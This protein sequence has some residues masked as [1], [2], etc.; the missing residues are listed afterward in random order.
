MKGV[1]DD[2][3]GPDIDSMLRSRI[4]IDPDADFDP[5][6]LFSASLDQEDI[7]GLQELGLNVEDEDQDLLSLKQIG[8]SPNN[9]S[10][11]EQDTGTANASMRSYSEQDKRDNDRF[12]DGDYRNDDRANNSDHN[13]DRNKNNSGKRKSNIQNLFV[14]SSSSPESSIVHERDQQEYNQG[15]EHFDPD[16]HD[17]GSRNHNR[18]S[19]HGYDAPSPYNSKADGESDH[20]NPSSERQPSL[21]HARNGRREKRDPHRIAEVQQ[22]ILHVQRKIRE[23]QHENMDQEQMQQNHQMMGDPHRHQQHYEQQEHGY[24]Q[25]GNPHPPRYQH[26]QHPQHPQHSQHRPSQN[27]QHQHHLERHER[28]RHDIHERHGRREHHER[29]ERHQRDQHHHHQHRGQHLP[30]HSHRHPHPQHQLHNH[31]HP[32]YRYAESYGEDSYHNNTK[33]RDMQRDSGFRPEHSYNGP[34]SS[35]RGGDDGFRGGLR[36]H[37]GPGSHQPPH[38][39]PHQHHGDSMRPQPLNGGHCHDGMRSDG[40]GN[41]FGPHDRM[42]PM[43][44]MRRGHPSHP[45]AHSPNNVPPFSNNSRV[46]FGGRSGG[47]QQQQH[48]VGGMSR[49]L[50]GIPGHSNNK[51]GNGP[52]MQQHGRSQDMPS[53]MSRSLNGSPLGRRMQS[54]NMNNSNGVMRA[55]MGIQSMSDSLNGM[56]NG[57]QPIDRHNKNNSLP[58]MMERSNN[59]IMQQQNMM[60]ASNNRSMQPQ[61]GIQS[62]SNSLNGIQNSNNGSDGNRNNLMTNNSISPQHSRG[63]QSMARSLNGAQQGSSGRRMSRSLNGM[64]DAEG[65]SDFRRHHQGHHP[66]AQGMEM[67][68]SL[69]GMQNMQQN[70]ND[71][72]YR[73]HQQDGMNRSNPMSASQNG[74]PNMNGSQDDY[75]QQQPRGGQNA[76]RGMSQSL[77]GAQNNSYTHFNH[78]QPA[79]DQMNNITGNR[80]KHTVI[81]GSNEM[82]QSNNMSMNASNNGPV[83]N[84]SNVP[85]APLLN[86]VSNLA[87]LPNRGGGNSPRTMQQPQ[88]QAPMA[89]DNPESPSEQGG[90][91]TSKMGNPMALAQAT[92]R[93]ASSR[94]MI[95]E[96][97]LSLVKLQRDAGSGGQSKSSSSSSTKPTVVK[98]KRNSGR[99]SYS[100]LKMEATVR[101]HARQIKVQ[102]QQT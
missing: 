69:N 68:R 83:L 2:G 21:R 23:A 82:P 76:L 84:N 58:S 59:G 6:C 64:P 94:K 44:S 37:D 90:N 77:N 26:P 67:S 70:Y 4:T 13:H 72:T 38:L 1:G 65:N 34:R 80:D 88:G 39:P 27:Q 85:S 91:G 11:V 45:M 15:Q 97:G 33:T 71:G 47:M 49:S 74:M 9:S 53:R 61:R 18:R 41:D 31:T 14:A 16:P 99:E 86:Q 75:G 5:S 96:L 89:E 10:Q 62:M 81:H 22:R 101:E 36:R 30:P 3:N 8:A 40:N 102:K 29:H 42:H 7:D 20:G 50:N 25:D 56:S 93:S 73:H 51:M 52:T 46:E 100:S 98:A 57:T 78:H 60:D 12:Y 95:K 24:A 92:M 43:D 28:E 48:V 32:Q 35:M 54:M 19:P 63:V 17:R 79:P 66:Q 87:N 55:R